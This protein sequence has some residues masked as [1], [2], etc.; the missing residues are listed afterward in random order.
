MKIEAEIIEDLSSKLTDGYNELA[1]AML[2]N[3]ADES[4]EV[5]VDLLRLKMKCA[6]LHALLEEIETL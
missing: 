6:A 4:G 5:E 3:K 2:H 1:K